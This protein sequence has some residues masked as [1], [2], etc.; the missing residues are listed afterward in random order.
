MAERWQPEQLEAFATALFAAT[1][2]D[3]EKAATTARLLVAADLMGHTTHG[4][5]LAGAYLDHAREGKMAVTG[6]PEFAVRVPV[7]RDGVT[8]YVLSASVKPQSILAQLAVQRLPAD[9]VGVVLDGQGRIVARTVAD[10][11]SVGQ[12]ASD[13]LRA[14]L[15]RSPEG[16]FR[17]STIEGAEVYTPYNRSPTTGWAVAM[18]IPAAVVEAGGDRDWG[19][20][21]WRRP[22]PARRADDRRRS[23][24]RW[25]QRRR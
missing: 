5:Q 25:R 21:G 19:R 14:A 3:A 2:L 22:C 4:L 23:R 18:G 11:R 13:S 7:T 6:E 1:G 9:W 17:G 24:H 20:D 15:A 16:W 8:K 10:E 12:L